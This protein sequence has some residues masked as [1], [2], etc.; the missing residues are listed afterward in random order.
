V[1]ILLKRIYCNKYTCTY[2]HVHDVLKK[3][4][5]ESVPEIGTW[6][7]RRCHCAVGCGR[8]IWLQMPCIRRTTNSDCTLRQPAEGG[9]CPERTHA[10]THAGTYYSRGNGVHIVYVARATVNGPQTYRT[11]SVE[12]VR[13]SSN[14]WPGIHNLW[15]GQV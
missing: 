13:A 14:T 7:Q 12:K 9:S 8:Q 10:G 6:L 3:E 2:V 15:S 4:V 11:S 5:R 1:L